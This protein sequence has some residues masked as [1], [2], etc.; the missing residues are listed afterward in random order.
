MSNSRFVLAACAVGVLSVVASAADA[1]SARPTFAELGALPEAERRTRIAAMSRDEIAALLRETS[2]EMLVRV[3]RETVAALGTYRMR[4]VKQE[5]VGGK[6]L[7]TQEMEAYVREKPFAAKMKYLKGPAAGRVLVYD[8]TLRPKEMRV[9]EAGLLGVMAVW[10]DIDGSLSRRDSNHSI[11]ELGFGPLLAL[12]ERDVKLAAKAG[13]FT[14]QHEGF[15]AEGHHC[16]VYVT[17]KGLA[18]AYAE[19]TRICVDPAAG[20]PVSVASYDAKGLFERFEFRDVKAKATNDPT[21]FDPA[22]WGL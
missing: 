2:P 20:L 6:L 7:E 5:R 19:R 9:R 21:F 16:S 18:D 13:G 1:P 15:D 17:P 10:V 22:K 3:S 12:F 11:R 4:L 14:V 8:E